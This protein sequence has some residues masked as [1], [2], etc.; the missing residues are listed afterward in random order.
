MTKKI[1]I[2][3]LIT[4]LRSPCFAEADTDTNT[5]DRLLSLD[6]NFLTTGLQNQ[7]WGL[8][9]KYER[10]IFDH[11]SVKGGFGHMTFQTGIE[12][13]N[14]AS[15]NIS[16]F[17]NYYPFGKG[18]D[19]LYIGTGSGGDF[20][21][22]FGEGILPESGNDVLISLTPIVGY[23]FNLKPLTID[24]NAGYKFVINESSNYSDV[25]SYVNQGIQLGLGFNF[26]LKEI[27]SSLN[28]LKKKK[29]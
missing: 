19:K 12:D 10:S 18:L 20:M 21:N 27:K 2:I 25:G 28:G 4:F 23:K 11:F 17:V 1:T 6:I 9:V 13:V 29:E 26:R 16:L 5:I 15:V 22:Y 7:G 8:G 3:L 24:I 14:C